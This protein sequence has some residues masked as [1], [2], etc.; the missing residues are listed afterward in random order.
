MQNSRAR[1]EE[2]GP[3]RGPNRERNGHA[4][5]T[6]FSKMASPPSGPQTGNVVRTVQHARHYRPPQRFTTPNEINDLSSL[7]KVV[8]RKRVIVK[9]EDEE[10][11]SILSKH[12]Y[13]SDARSRRP[14]MLIQ[15]ARDT[16]GGSNTNAYVKTNTNYS[17]ERGYEYG[18]EDD[19]DYE[20]YYDQLPPRLNNTPKH[21][22]TIRHKKH[23]ISIVNMGKSV[24]TGRKESLNQDIDM[25]QLI[26]KYVNSESPKET[27]A[28]LINIGLCEKLNSVNREMERMRGEMSEMWEFIQHQLKIKDGSKDRLTMQTPWPG[29]NGG[30]STV[31]PTP[32]GASPAP[33]PTTDNDFVVPTIYGKTAVDCRDVYNDIQRKGKKRPG[34]VFLTHFLRNLC[35]QAIESPHRG[36]LTVRSK[37]RHDNLIN[38]AVEFMK[39]VENFFLAACNVTSGLTYALGDMLREALAH[40]LRE[41]RRQPRKEKVT[42]NDNMMRLIKSMGGTRHISMIDDEGHVMR[43]LN[44]HR[45]SDSFQNGDDNEEREEIIEEESHEDEEHLVMEQEVEVEEQICA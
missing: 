29:E 13:E 3:R 34:V 41:L 4:R 43:R 17:T 39:P 2:C 37:N 21:H 10:E 8:G 22:S 36:M 26:E 31:M 12:K 23:P 9:Q 6:H 25:Q 42:L 11:P 28:W 19:E 7:V 44:T 14:P 35:A 16:A 30:G 15:K 5:I 24:V 45:G 33:T 20:E 40:E 18:L 1:F 32:F 38:I 27:E